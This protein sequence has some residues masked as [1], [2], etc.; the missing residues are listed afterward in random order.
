M[1]QPWTD[2][3]LNVDER[4]EAL[5][6]A[7]TVDE[8]AGQL[9][10]FWARP[11]APS[12]EGN[13]VA[14][15]EQVMSSGGTF[16]ESTTNGLGHLTRVFG[17]E[18]IS[19][20]EGM[21]RMVTMQQAVVQNSRLGVPAIA[22]EE[23]LTGFTAYGA[24][25]YPA[26]IAWG[27]TF[28]PELIQEMAVA[29]GEDMRQVGVHQG[30]SPLLDVVRDYR[31]GRVEETIGEDPQLVGTLGTA[32]V[33]GL[34]SAGIMATL[35]HFVGYSASRAGRNHAPVTIGRRELEDILLPPF[36]MAVREGQVAC[37]MNSYSDVDGVPVAASH[38]LLTEV[39]RDRWGFEGAVVS[40]YWSVAFLQT[41]HRVAADL[42][43]AGALSLHA[44]MDVEL[45]ETS[46]FALLP[47]AI[48]A[49]QVSLDEVR[50][51]AR[52]VLRQKAKLGLL[53]AEW[54]PAQPVDVDLDSPR[55]RDIA[56]RVAEQSIVLLKNEDDLLP[57]K[58]RKVALLGPICGDPL[59]F[60]GCYAFPNHV[61]PRYPELPTGIE[62]TNLA[63]AIRVEFGDQVVVEQGVGILD[64]DRSGIEQAVEAARSAEV[65]IVAVGD[66]A[67]MFGGGTSGEGCDSVDL[68]LPGV[69][70]ELVEAVLATGTPT[71]LLVVSGRPYALGDY[72]DRCQ[73]IVQAFMPGEEGGAAIAGVLSGRVDP[74]GR[75][76]LGIPNHPGGQP[77]TYIAAPLAWWS[78]GVSNLDP[79]PLFP[80]G[81]GLAYNR[82]EVH[83]LAVE[84]SEVATDGSLRFSVQVSNHGDTETREV[85]QVY[86]G[87]PVAT[88]VRPLKQLAAYRKVSVPAGETRTLTFELHTDLMSFT[89]LDM[90]R[91]VEPGEI[92]L[93]VGTSSEDLPLTASV[94][95]IGE[96][97]QVGE[98][99]TLVAD[100]T[101]A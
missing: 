9:G 40:D 44:G 54:A 96:V 22:H 10:S 82:A 99:R 31:W 61:L 87:D 80:F 51:A 20:Q 63:D 8:L 89:G 50:E 13:D 19:T 21:Q 60:M 77:G 68:S 25:V 46:A 28:D 39:L 74:C 73:A 95:L 69:Q 65:A 7:M 12:A 85:V 90:K 2:P 48:E 83:D 45:P 32:Y 97:R 55:N 70:G 4:V 29:I 62:L 3:N 23:C 81:H 27:A 67:G 16:A 52:R 84:S 58:A 11:Q 49:G 92:Q 5:I 42:Q 36:E 26:A 56:R 71:I 1:S 53:D 43:E 76:P 88:V 30:L 38:D 101:V 24:T 75:L 17:S 79:R 34:Q 94:N 33:K 37:V 98:G 64:T 66:R 41:M 72:A 100:V 78:D 57:L 91:R 6:D 14:P 59:T 86:L 93:M 47:A 15:M 18:P 35:K